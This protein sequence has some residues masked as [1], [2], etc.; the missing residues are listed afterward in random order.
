MLAFIGSIDAAGQ[1]RLE[2]LPGLLEEAGHRL[3]ILDWAQVETACED[4]AAKL[5]SR[6]SA[7]ELCEAALVGIPRGGTIVAGLLAYA[8]NIPRD[9]LTATDQSDVTILVDDGSISGVRLREALTSLTPT[10][11]VIVATLASDPALRSAVVAEEARV[12]AF[13]SGIDLHDHTDAI[14]G[15]DAE[16]WRVRWRT[17]VPQRYH[18][19]LL[20]LLVFPWSEPEVRLWNPVTGVVEP[21]WWLAPPQSCLHHRAAAPGLLIRH[22]DDDPA[23]PYLAPGVIAVTTDEAVTLVATTGGHTVTLAGIAAELWGAWVDND[24]VETA[25]MSVTERFAVGTDRARHDL[26][27]LLSDLRDRRYLAE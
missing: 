11:R 15:S 24:S 23:S 9:R 6:F 3:R 22:V 5:R 26:S 19:A 2:E 25:V 8:L 17:E 12:E 13:V 27:A 4:L 18:T 7:E 21:S 14:L 1:A 20:D 10:R 16:A